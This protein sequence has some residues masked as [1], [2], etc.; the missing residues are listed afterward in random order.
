MATSKED[1]YFRDCEAQQ[2]LRPGEVRGLLSEI[3]R[4]VLSAV[5]GF[6]NS[7]GRRRI[8]VRGIEN[9]T[10]YS[11]MAVIL[12]CYRLTGLGL[13]AE[14]PPPKNW[15]LPQR[16]NHQGPGPKPSRD[17]ALAEVRGREQRAK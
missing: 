2:Y 14:A 3:D 9:K 8:T 12:S 13:L 4:A 6:H 5:H 17:E 16:L 7:R 1:I 15:K 11:G 10:G